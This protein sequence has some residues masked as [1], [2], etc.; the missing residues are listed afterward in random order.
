MTPLLRSILLEAVRESW[1]CFIATPRA[2]ST[3]KHTSD[4]YSQAPFSLVSPPSWQGA[5]GC[6]TASLEFIPFSEHQRHR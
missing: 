3:S 2:V 4:L 1:H 6:P 5:D